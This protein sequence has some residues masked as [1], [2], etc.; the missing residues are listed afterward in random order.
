MVKHLRKLRWIGRDQEADRIVRVLT[1]NMQKLLEARSL[2]T[3][4]SR[5][6]LPGERE[7]TCDRQAMDPLSRSI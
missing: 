6:G 2:E 4:R 7:E 3:A 5:N 1:I